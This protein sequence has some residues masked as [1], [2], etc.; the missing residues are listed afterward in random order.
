MISSKL[1]KPTYDL[2]KEKAIVGGLAAARFVC[3]I[4]PVTK[5]AIGYLAVLP[6]L[7]SIGSLV[8]FHF[9]GDEYGLWVLGSIAG[10]WVAFIMPN[11]GDIHHWTLRAAVVGTGALT[12]FGAGALL[13]WLKVPIR[14]WIAGWLVSAPAM[15]ALSLRGVS[16]FADALAKNGSWTAYGLFAS[17]AAATLTT[18]LCILAGA[19]AQGWRNRH[20]HPMDQS[21]P[22]G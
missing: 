13:L 4:K 20:A 9:P 12:M 21:G 14:A 22:V 16:S 18:A 17:L 7:W 15:L 1:T 5:S 8:H 19:V 2:F 10:S 3:Q 6:A 11:T